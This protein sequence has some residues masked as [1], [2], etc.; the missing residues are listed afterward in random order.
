MKRLS[1]AAATVL[2]LAAS[3]FAQT[4][5]P[6]VTAEM[7]QT[8][9]DA[10]QKGDWAAAAAAYERILSLDHANVGARYRLGLSLLSLNKL[11]EART[12]LETAFTASP[13]PFFAHALARA[14]ARGGNRE[15]AFE[16]LEKSL[17]LGGILPE[18]LKSEKDFASF[19]ADSRFTDLVRKSDL[20][21]NPCK[22]SPEFRQFDFWVGE[23]DAKNAQGLTVGTSSIQLI[24][25]ECVIFEN[26]NTPVNSGKSFSIF[27]AKDKRWHQSWVDD[28]GTR[29]EYVGDLVDGKMVLVAETSIA[30]K[31]ALAKMTYTKL[32]NGDVRQFGENSADGGKT[33]K[34]SFDFT[35]VRKK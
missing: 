26:W 33:W 2:V 8:A 27:D 32:A 23:W 25:G 19:A 12:N 31:A 14:Y 6:S 3:L 5:G 4:T 17:T 11:D 10:Y 22:A 29:T 13:N 16:V 24:L 28:K 35:Y 15:K 21:V 20:A 7:R 30:G 1:S 34:P 9:N 18:T